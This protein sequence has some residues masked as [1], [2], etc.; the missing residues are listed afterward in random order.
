MR[1]E[2]KGMYASRTGS[3][4][5]LMDAR[6][7]KGGYQDEDGEDGECGREEVLALSKL[8]SL[9]VSTEILARHSEICGL[10]SCE[11]AKAVRRR[12]RVVNG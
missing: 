1:V 5:I 3:L 4:Q 9:E 10:P 12:Q 2:L 11:G 8:C 7:R 6:C